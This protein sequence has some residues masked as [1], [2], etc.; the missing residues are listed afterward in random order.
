MSEKPDA[1]R[2]QTGFRP[3]LLNRNEAP[4]LVPARMVNEVLYCERLMVLEWVHGEFADNFFT[5]EGR[6]AH[7]KADSPGGKPLP[8]PGNG[9][10]SETEPF[11][12][13]SVW[14]SSEK[15][16]LT[17][18]IDVVD[19]DGK[20]VSPIEYK[21]GKR[22]PVPENA[23][24]PERAQLCAQVLLLREAGYEC[25]NAYVYYAGNKARYP[26][27]ITE[28]L[29]SQTLEAIA[30]AK[31]LSRQ[32]TL[33]PPLEDSPKC[34]GCSLIGIC[35]PDEIGFLNQ[36]QESES[37]NSTRQERPKRLRRLH[38]RNQDRAAFTA[39]TQGTRVGVDGGLLVIKKKQERLAEARLT[40]TSQVDLYGNVQLTTQALRALL[41]KNIPVNYFTYG[42]WYIGR[43]VG[44]GSKNVDLRLAQYRAADDVAFCLGVARSIVAAKILNCRTLLRRNSA[45]P[46]RITLSEL[47][48][49]A[50]KARR[51][52]KLESLLGIEGTA[53]RI[54]FRSFTG[55]L[56]GN[57]R[58]L[59]F[60]F[61]TRNRRPPLD[62]LN[63]LLSFCYSL[64]T[65]ELSVAVSSVGLDPL[66]GFY[67]QP[68]FG[69]PALALDLME[70]F[71]PLLADS[72]VLTALNN[73]VIG[74]DDFLRSNVG[75][76]LKS[77]ARKR[78]I[79]A[80]ERRLAQQVTHPIF[81]YRISYR[82]ILEVQARL[83][84]RLLLGEI[85]EYPSFRTR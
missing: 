56:R 46:C 48:Q 31:R 83:F 12:A 54:Y 84:S 4:L 24:L 9:G 81:G 49:L 47:K 25:D 35:L 14:L 79:L 67:H 77:A 85:S 7:T 37:L 3:K 52:Q 15:L 65:R 70:E 59:E 26:V 43:T 82:R 36:K 10:A 44:H 11:Q 51:S 21:R 80:Y 61:R 78:L 8:V 2:T 62:P 53:A 1:Q 5:V 55:M 60:D 58:A 34:K 74:T 20:Q 50:R 28:T 18:K 32:S 16:S 41:K 68:R 19:V 27:E 22:P 73:G 38:P 69:R 39:Q 72:T 42:G 33:P 17:A 66:L 71:R 75:V 23:R 13:R 63:A 6:T 64:L 29:I 76:S 40:N 57:A 30:R 45:R